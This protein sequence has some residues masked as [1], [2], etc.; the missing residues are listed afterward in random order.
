MPCDRCTEPFN[1]TIFGD[2]ELAVKFGNMGDVNKDEDVIYISENDDFIDVSSLIY[3]FVIVSV[4]LRCVHQEDKNGKSACDQETISKLS[5]EQEARFDPR[6]A[7]LE[8]LKN[9]K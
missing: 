1:Q 4:P 7:A 5:N 8:K 6:W 2:Y 3:E 9:K